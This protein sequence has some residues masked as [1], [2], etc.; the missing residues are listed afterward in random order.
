[1]SLPENMPSPGH[2]LSLYLRLLFPCRSAD[3]NARAFPRPGR[4][5]STSSQ[6]NELM[7]NELR[8]RERERSVA[9]VNELAWSTSSEVVSVRGL[10][11][12]ST[13]SEVVCVICREILIYI[14]FVMC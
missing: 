13:S 11:L 1:M 14:F 6:A 2:E 3:R 9:W 8:G 5:W 12:G 7:V 4:F 10:W